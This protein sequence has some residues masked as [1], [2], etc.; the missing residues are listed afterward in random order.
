MFEKKTAQISG[1]GLFQKMLQNYGGNSEEGD[2]QGEASSAAALEQQK[3]AEMSDQAPYVLIKPESASA[4][5]VANSVWL[6]Y[7][8]KAGLKFALA[9][10]GLV[11]YMAARTFAGSPF[12]FCFAVK[13]F[14]PQNQQDFWLAY[15]VNG[16]FDLSYSVWAGVFGAVTGC[17]LLVFFFA[18]FLLYLATL[19]ASQ[20]LHDGSF[21]KLLHGTMQFFDATPIGRILNRF[22]KDIDRFAFVFSFVVRIIFIF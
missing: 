9:I 7:I 14:F 5:T 13:N 17:A 6:T 4:K 22:S 10:I 2:T 21:R 11:F 16:S 20:T 3:S 8:S 12:L 1:S 19:T 15:Y 18:D